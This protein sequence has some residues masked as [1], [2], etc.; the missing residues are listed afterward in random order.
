MSTVTVKPDKVDVT[1]KPGESETV[2]KTVDSPAFPPKSDIVFL[3]DTTGSMT[4][5][6]Q[7]VKENAKEILKEILDAQPTA[8][9]AVTDY[10][11]KEHDNMGAYDFHVGQDFTT[12][13]DDVVAAINNWTASP[14]SNDWPE[15][16]LLALYKLA[17]DGV[18]W[19]P[20]ST[21]IIVWFGDAEGH[22]D[23][24]SLSEVIEALKAAKIKV[25]AISV[26]SSSGLGPQADK[27]A[28]AT[29][30]AHLRDADPS[31]VAD[32][33]L[34]SLQNLPITVNPVIVDPGPLLITFDP[35]ESTVKSGEQAE[36]T[37]KI[38]LPDDPSLTGKIDV[39]CFVEFRD[40]FTTELLAKSSIQNIS[41]EISA[42]L[43]KEVVVRGT[44]KWLD[45]GV[46]IT[47]RHEITI[48]AT[49][50]WK[51]DGLEQTFWVD[52]NGF[53]TFKHPD[54]ILPDE[55]FAS[56][57]G[58]FGDNGTPFFVGTNFGP[59]TPGPGR[60]F[61]QMNDIKGSFFDN[62]GELNVVIQ[63]V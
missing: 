22:D 29:D 8:Q 36:F 31:T 63:A 41:I 14:Y 60:L 54:A 20:N 24:P 51:N 3:A 26:T 32:L 49:G 6:L 12:N 28:S 23:S 34:E 4:K 17:T 16:Q 18:S 46:E 62:E 50:R 48:T 37:E 61:L 38:E 1:L 57:I 58:R 56:L 19:R 15:N 43:T 53:G 45:T 40:K 13:I 7:N 11:D 5:G 44:D 9:F 21:P 59:S 27:I 33:M 10:K 35:S 47:A 42:P 30:G 2:L 39:S 55:N 25:I 52:A